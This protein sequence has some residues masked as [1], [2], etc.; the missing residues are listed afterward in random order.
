MIRPRE[1]PVAPEGGVAVL[2]G[3]LCPD[4]AVIQH[5]GAEP[6]LL[7]HTGPAVVFDDYR[8]MQRTIDDPSLGITADSVLVLRNSG[9]LGGPGMPEYGMLPIPE[10]LLKQG[11]RDMVRISDSRMSGTSYGTRVL[12]VAPES[13]V[14]GPQR[15]LPARCLTLSPHPFGLSPHPSDPAPGERRTDVVM[16]ADTTDLSA[17]HRRYVTQCYAEGDVDVVFGRATAVFE[18]CRFHTLTRTDLAPAL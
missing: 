2:R 11:V 16:V 4:G 15:A 13:A 14:G 17:S 9:P 1:N 6:R 8:T 10:Y 3:N 7:H 18:D 12:H 5:I